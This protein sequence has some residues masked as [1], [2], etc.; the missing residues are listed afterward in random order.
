MRVHIPVPDQVGAPEWIGELAPDKG[1]GAKDLL[2]VDLIQ[3]D[4]EIVIEI[5]QRNIC[6]V[7]IIGI[8]RDKP[9]AQFE[10][11][12]GRIGCRNTATDDAARV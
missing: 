7:R 5:R 10:V 6:R 3:T 11:R 2:A 1:E 4:L 8:T 12:R 9:C